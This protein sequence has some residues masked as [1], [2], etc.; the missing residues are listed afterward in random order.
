MNSYNFY[1]EITEEYTFP[2]APDVGTIYATV[3]FEWGDEIVARTAATLVTG[4]TYSITIPAESVDSWG[5]WRIKWECEFSATAFYDFTEFGVSRSY[6]DEAG[7]ILDYPEFND[8]SFSGD[9]F[10]TAERIARHIVDTH[11]GQSFQFIKNKTLNIDGNGRRYIRL[12]YNIEGIY[13]VLVDSGDYTTAVERDVKSKRY[14]RVANS[15]DV[16]TLVYS[17]FANDSNIEI[18]ADWGWISIPQNIVDATEMLICDIIDDV[19]RE[20]YRYNVQRVWQ[21]TNR[22]ELNVQGYETT[23]NLDVDVLL[24]DYVMWDLDYVS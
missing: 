21:D 12:P 9:I 11:C 5:V 15:N 19:R 8:P 24:M 2:N 23:G 10:V 20:N 6:T 13:S 3:Y 14:I 1:T 18:T 22:I 7:F 16:D 4:N 17:K